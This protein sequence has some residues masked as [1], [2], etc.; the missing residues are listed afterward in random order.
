MSTHAAGGWNSYNG[1]VASCA[2]AFG[3]VA[4]I[5]D[6]ARDGSMP[7]VTGVPGGL[8]LVTPCSPWLVLGALAAASGRAA[9]DS[10]L[11]IIETARS[12][13]IVQRSASHMGIGCVGGLPAFGS[14]R[15]STLARRATAVGWCGIDAEMPV[16]VCQ[17][18]RRADQQELDVLEERG[19]LALDFVPYE[20]ADPGGNED[21]DEQRPGR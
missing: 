2:M 4:H 17:Q 13:P 5:S 9:V 8:N 12:V 7:V 20:L 1:G 10:F 16:K 3:P 11:W 14:P 19:L 18:P 6:I 21:A 15:A